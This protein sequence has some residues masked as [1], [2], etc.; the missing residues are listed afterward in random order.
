MKR[1][2][3]V[4]GA[5]AGIGQAAVN[6]LIERGYTTD[7]AA[8]RYAKPMVFMSTVLPDRFS[9]WFMGA[10]TKSLLKQQR[11]ESATQTA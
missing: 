11:K 1:V 9:N 8:R 6:R 3:V 4:T 10:I 7:A 5:S 2:A